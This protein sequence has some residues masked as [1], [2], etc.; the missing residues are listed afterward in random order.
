MVGR[1]PPQRLLRPGGQ[2]PVVRIIFRA[3]RVVACKRRGFLHAPALYHRLDQKV[4]Q[5]RMVRI[6]F[7]RDLEHFRRAGGIP[8]GQHGLGCEPVDEGRRGRVLAQGFD[9]LQRL[10]HLARTQ[11]RARMTVAH[12]LIRLARGDPALVIAQ[13]IDRRPRSDPQLGA[14]EFEIRRVEHLAV[15][16]LRDPVAHVGNPLLGQRVR[17][18]ITGGVVLVDA[19]RTLQSLEE[20]RHAA[21]I[22]VGTVQDLQADPVRLALER[23]RVA[24]LRLDRTR[25]T[26]RQCS[27]TDLR[28]TPGRENG[29]QQG[30]QHDHR[31]LALATIKLRDVALRDMRDLMSEYRRQFGF[32]LRA[33]DQTG[34]QA[35]IAARQRERVQRRIPDH[36][37]LEIV[38]GVIARRGQPAPQPIDIALDL[39]VV[40]IA[41]IPPANLLD[42]LLAD[43][44]LRKRGQSGRGHIAQVG[45]IDRGTG[46]GQRGT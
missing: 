46:R 42:D 33:Q 10:R 22:H 4:A 9:R 11:Q 14:N 32:S 37:E 43:L 13:H 44:P 15:S 12:E 23:A 41:R 25:L 17:A 7:D 24:D 6:A 5:R 35:D 31:R 39:P 20:T 16:H 45:K 1:H 26:G 29:D 36:E 34:V 30:S 8:R 19:G 21:H 38:L 28:I 18:Q 2:R 27:L 40:E 3:H